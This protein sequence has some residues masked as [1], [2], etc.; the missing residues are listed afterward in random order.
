MKEFSQAARK[1]LEKNGFPCYVRGKDIYNVVAE[2]MALGA[3]AAH[4]LRCQSCDGY[5]LRDTKQCFTDS[6]KYFA[7]EAERLLDKGKE[8]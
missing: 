4:N 7:A 2:A 6:A 3:R 1:L 8:S 5:R